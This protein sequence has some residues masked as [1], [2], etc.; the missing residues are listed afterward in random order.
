MNDDKKEPTPAEVVADINNLVYSELCGFHEPSS[1]EHNLLALATLTYRTDGNYE[2]IEFLGQ[3]LW[4]DQDNGIPWDDAK[5]EPMRPLK[6]HL[7]LKM[8]QTI[9]ALS[10]VANACEKGVGT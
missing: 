5:D 2:G 3:N 7:R 8:A 6:D 1:D 9:R 4:D 10:T